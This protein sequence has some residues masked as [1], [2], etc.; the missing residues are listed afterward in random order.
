MDE[1][2][3]ATFI[4]LFYIGIFFHERSRFAPMFFVFIISVAFHLRD[5]NP[6]LTSDKLA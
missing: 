5:P 2:F 6:P 1:L 4:L 3:V